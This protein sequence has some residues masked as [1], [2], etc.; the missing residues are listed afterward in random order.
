MA[1]TDLLLADVSAEVALSDEQRERIARLA[2]RVA[3]HYRR[4]ERR[5]DT[6]PWTPY[7]ERVFG[8]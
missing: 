5:L 3:E 1:L 7:A 6:A 8:T 4:R 2:E